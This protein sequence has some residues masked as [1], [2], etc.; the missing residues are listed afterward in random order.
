[1]SVRFSVSCNLKKCVRRNSISVMSRWMDILRQNVGKK[2]IKLDHSKSKA[3]KT[4]RHTL[5]LH[6]IDNK[7]LSCERCGWPSGFGTPRMVSATRDFGSDSHPNLKWWIYWK[8]RPLHPWFPVGVQRTRHR[9]RWLMRC[10]KNRPRKL[11]N[12]NQTKPN[13]T[14]FGIDLLSLIWQKTNQIVK[15]RRI[16]KWTSN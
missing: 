13:H 12:R 3:V 15:I 11:I 7:C 1:M 14:M 2:T 9:V 16:T 10:T 8:V 6:H 4:W 5:A